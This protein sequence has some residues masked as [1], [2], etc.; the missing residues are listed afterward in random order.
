MRIT[1]LSS[2]RIKNKDET[3]LTYGSHPEIK[4]RVGSSVPGYVGF[5]EGSEFGNGNASQISFSIRDD[6]RGDGR[7]DQTSRIAVQ[8]CAA[9]YQNPDVNANYHRYASHVKIH[10]KDSLQPQRRGIVISRPKSTAISEKEIREFTWSVRSFTLLSMTSVRQNAS[11]RMT[12]NCPYM[13]L[14]ITHN[15]ELQKEKFIQ[16]GEKTR[17]T[18]ENNDEMLTR[19]LC[20]RSFPLRA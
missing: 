12:S 2:A 11:M 16:T 9:V 8:R 20:S 7:R 3:G 13:V 15:W 18:E 10:E 6:A 1:S 5:F 4:A 17:E 14:R 19:V